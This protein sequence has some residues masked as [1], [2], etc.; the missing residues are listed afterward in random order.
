MKIYSA[1]GSYPTANS[2]RNEIER[3]IGKRYLITTRPDVK[4]DILFR[5][6]SNFPTKGNDPNFNSVDFIEICR[7]KLKFSKFCKENNIY[8]PIYHKME[9]LP[10]NFPIII[11]T[12]LTGFQGRGIIPINS[13][14]EY[15]KN[16]RSSFWWTDFVKT[17]FEIRVHLFDDRIE[18]IYKKVKDGEESQFPIR[19]IENNYHFANKSDSL[20][21]YQKLIPICQNIGNLFKNLG[22]HFSA[23][24]IGYDIEKHNYFVFEANSAPGLN[25][26]SVTDYANYFISS[27]GLKE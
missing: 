21:K 27:L 26:L 20:D 17:D 10:E 12:T 22:G 8:S 16:M 25:S 18:K 2:I 13:I 7:D 19:N 4:S 1:S 24:D 11:R 15:Q 14:E 5:Y 3:L 9:E 23:L 6:G